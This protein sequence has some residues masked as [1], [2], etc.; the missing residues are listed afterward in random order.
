MSYKGGAAGFV[1]VLDDRTL[2]FP[3]Y[4]GNGMFLSTGNITAAGRVGLLF[5][6]L[7]RPQR[8]RVHGRA[9]ITDDAAATA[10]FPGGELVV[11]VTVGHAFANC[12]RYITPHAPSGPAKYVPDASGHQDLPDWK[13]IDGLQPFLP[14]RF[15]GTPQEELI[16]P[17]EYEDRLQRG[18][19]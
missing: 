6:D 10:A 17:E 14:D 11:R 16:T 19:T 13:K 2:V 15:Q 1:R 5:M 9:E 18:A 8:L 7:E 4:D 12:A 3:S